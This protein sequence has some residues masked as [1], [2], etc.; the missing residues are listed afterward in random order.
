GRLEEGT[1]APVMLRDPSSG[2][3]P[4]TIDPTPAPDSY[5]LIAYPSS[6]F[7]DGRDANEPWLREVPDPVTKI[8]WQGWIEIHPDAARRLGLGEGDTIDVESANG[9]IQATAH[10]SSDV[11]ADVVAMPIGFGRSSALRYAGGR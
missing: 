11:R 1:P 10:L 6:H 8:V 2:I 7:F 9:R 4:V 3:S 5:T